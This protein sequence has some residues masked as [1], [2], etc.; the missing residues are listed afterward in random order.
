MSANSEFVGNPLEFLQKNIIRVSY[1]AIGTQLKTFTLATREGYNA[2]SADG[3]KR[4]YYFLERATGPE[5]DAFQAYWCGYKPNK[6][7]YMTLVDDADV[8]FTATMSG[9]TFA[10]GSNT[11]S[12]ARLVGH[13]NS[14]RAASLDK[15]AKSQRKKAMKLVGSKGQLFEPDDYRPDPMNPTGD[16]R[17]ATTI[18]VRD[19]ITGKWTFYAQVY[20]LGMQ[21]ATLVDVKRIA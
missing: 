1:G 13:V 15:Q 6:T 11:P 9:C 17:D 4:G 7:I 5:P 21:E 10:V 8:M 16:P 19:Q 2:K 3:A 12:G 18:G 20:L 14:A